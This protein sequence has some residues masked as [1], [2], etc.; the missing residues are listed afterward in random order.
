MNAVN[1]VEQIKALKK[2]KNALIVAHYYVDDTV[3]EIADYVGDSYYLSKVCM[4]RPEELIIFCGVRF[5]G[6]SAKILNPYKQVIMAEEN[7]DCP[8]AHMIEIEKIRK[9]RA[10]YEDLAVVCY[11]NS[12]TEIKAEADVVELPLMH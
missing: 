2:Q 11:I 9:V 3:Q 6:E 7:A 8:M 10:T 1:I 5:M 12:T 4:D